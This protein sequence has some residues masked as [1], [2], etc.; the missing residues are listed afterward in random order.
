MNEELR[1]KLVADLKKSGFAS[2]MFALNVF[3]RLGWQA[4]SGKGYIDKDENITREIDIS[5]YLPM[6]LMH[7]GTPYASIDFHIIAEV[8]KTEKP[9]IVFKQASKGLMM[10]DGWRNLIFSNNLPSEGSELADSI[11][12]NSLISEKRWTGSG[13][14][15]AF[16]DPSMPSRWYKSF[17]SVCKACEYSYD[18]TIDFHK[19]FLG[20]SLDKITSDVLTNSTTFDFFQPVVILDGI[21]VSAELSDDAEVHLEDVSSAPFWFEFRTKNYSRREYRVDL[22][23]TQGLEEYLTLV[24]QRQKG[25]ADRIRDLSVS[26]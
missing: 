18:E 24:K 15:H 5:A 13:I 20:Q 17:I 23:T 8:K 2:E 3:Q 4:R 11:S 26:H 6:C 7:Q 19:N 22:V 14:H 12:K 21:L 1:R 9:W 10:G 25:I 16:K